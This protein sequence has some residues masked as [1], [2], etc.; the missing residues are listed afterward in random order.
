MAEKFIPAD[1]I[2]ELIDSYWKYEADCRDV[3]SEVG[4]SRA[5]L[6]RTVIDDLQELLPRKTLADIPKSE[7]WSYV[8]MWA[9]TVN[10]TGNRRMSVIGSVSND[11]VTLVHP[12]IQSVVS[13]FSLDSIVPRN[14]IRRAWS[15]DG[16]PVSEWDE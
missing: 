2:S 4:N 5:G 12:A 3:G 1:K 10:Q 6:Y 14:D 13:T 7:R 9:D 8:G 16:A 15:P 11:L